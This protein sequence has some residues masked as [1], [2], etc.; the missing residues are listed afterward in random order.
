MIIVAGFPLSV[1]IPLFVRSKAV[2]LCVSGWKS[3]RRR[4]GRCFLMAGAPHNE[5]QRNEN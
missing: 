5:G 1:C 2:A 4:C 3:V